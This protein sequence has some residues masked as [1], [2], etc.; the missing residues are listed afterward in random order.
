MRCADLATAAGDTGH[1]WVLVPQEYADS[2]S[3]EGGQRHWTHILWA[4]PCG[5]F[6]W[7]SYVEREGCETPKWSVITEHEAATP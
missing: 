6:R 2:V 7:T 3:A 5:E 1:D 4:C